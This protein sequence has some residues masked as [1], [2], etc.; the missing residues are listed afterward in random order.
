MSK[1]VSEMDIPGVD[2]VS[3][4]NHPFYYPAAGQRVAV[5]CMT[6]RLI[7]GETYLVGNGVLQFVATDPFGRAIM[8]NIDCYFTSDVVNSGVPILC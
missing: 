5:S 6:H 8:L 3:T 1:T 4:V 2:H 7:P